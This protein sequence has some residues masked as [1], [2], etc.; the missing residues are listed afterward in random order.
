MRSGRDTLRQI[1]RG[2]GDQDGQWPDL[3]KLDWEIPDNAVMVNF[4]PRILMQLCEYAVANDNKSIELAITPE[5]VEPVIFATGHV[6]GQMSVE[7]VIFATGHVVGQIH[8][9]A[10]EKQDIANEHAKNRRDIREMIAALGLS[11][12]VAALDAQPEKGNK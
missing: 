2:A 4:T 7:P 10:R 6:V 11:P 9:R 3:G 12:D 1:Y 8:V 5:S